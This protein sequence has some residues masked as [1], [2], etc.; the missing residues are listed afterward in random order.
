MKALTTATLL[1]TFFGMAGCVT[2]QP[3]S[4][5]APPIF[6]DEDIAQRSQRTPSVFQQ[7][8]VK[9]IRTS[10]IVGSYVTPGNSNHYTEAIR[11]N[12]TPATQGSTVTSAQITFYKEGDARLQKPFFNAGQKRIYLAYPESKFDQ[13][14]ETL[15]NSKKLRVTFYNYIDGQHVQGWISGSDR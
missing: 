5:P 7:L 10:V 8:S 3:S 4:N 9:N 14:H 15:R 12:G 11:L 6:M 2:T 1:L 13:V